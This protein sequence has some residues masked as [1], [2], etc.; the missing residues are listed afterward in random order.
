M[1][2]RRSRLRLILTIREDF[3]DRPLS[4][5]AFGE[6]LRE[7]AELLAAM[8]PEELQ[9][10]IE[11]PAARAGVRF[12]P[13]LVAQIVADVVD[14]TSALPL[15]QH[16]LTELFDRRQQRV[17]ELATYRELRGAVEALTHCADAVYGGL[18]P[19]ERAF[20]EASVDNRDAGQ[21]APRD[22]RAR[23]TRRQR[24]SRRRAAVLIGSSVALIAVS[25]VAASEVAHSRA[26]DRLAD[27]STQAHQLAVAS[28][29]VANKQPDL[30]MLLALQSLSTSAH[31]HLPALTEAEDALQWAVQ[32]AGLTYPTSDA[33]VD[34]RSGP[35]G[36]TG[37]FRLSLPA[38]VELAREHLRRGFTTA[39][40]RHYSLHPCPA[41]T[42]GLA[43]PA[44]TGA[45]PVPAAPPP[46]PAPTLARPLGQHHRDVA[47]RRLG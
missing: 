3:Y 39:E 31:Q 34:A 29:G 46:T 5:H 43:S 45:A 36:R 27:A 32:G 4:N 38:L 35:N 42:S 7:G 16:A 11:R 22:Q 37:D 30:A 33:P 44:S 20:L 41:S 13:G 1:L 26:T 19:S 10:A 18:A 21:V 40:C 15:L 47:R 28:R 9:R 6:L 17:I 12:E 24:R 14:H 2:D 23:E 8:S 25:T